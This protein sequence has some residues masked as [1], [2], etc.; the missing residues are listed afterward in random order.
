MSV[1]ERLGAGAPPGQVAAVEEGRAIYNNM[2]AF[3][4][5]MI[6]SNIG[7]VAS[8]FLTAALGLPEN[9]IPVQLL[10]VNLVTVRAQPPGH[11]PTLHLPW[12]V[13]AEGVAVQACRTAT[14]GLLCRSGGPLGLQSCCG[15][16]AATLLK[17]SCVVP[18][19]RKGGEPCALAHLQRRQCQ[20]G[21]LAGRAAVP[22]LDDSRGVVLVPQVVACTPCRTA[23]RRRPWA[24]TRRTWT[25]CRSRRGAPTRSSSR[26]GSSSGALHC[27]PLAP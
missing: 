3:I 12:R 22:M 18:A 16:G 11:P 5:Y 15:T 2:K 7:E 19:C 27:C 21:R 23:R 26:P 9:L 20:D 8:I 17:L 6:S 14:L 25:S 10:W 13:L 1:W 4:R 24:S